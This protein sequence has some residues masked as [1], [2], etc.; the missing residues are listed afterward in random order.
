MN[1]VSL[2]GRLTR[3]PEYR[4]SQ[5]GA[6]T[7]EITRFTLA[8]DRGG[9]NADFI[10][11]VAFGYNASFINK[12]FSKGSKM[13]LTGNLRTGSYNDRD[14]KKVYTTDVIVDKVGFGES[15]AEADARG[16]AEPQPSS[17]DIIGGD[18][19]VNVGDGL[20]AELPFMQ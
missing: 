10:S 16:A 12:Y 2:T 4:V 20:A 7:K 18:G 1:V 8:V 6:E 13:E 3:D 9:T 11:C 17:N 5:N 19:F 15:K 14:G